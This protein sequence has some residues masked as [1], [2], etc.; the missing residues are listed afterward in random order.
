MY[1]PS[2]AVVVP[3][4]GNEGSITA[5]VVFVSAV[6]FCPLSP[7]LTLCIIIVHNTL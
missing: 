7:A 3:F 6:M 4:G 2:H 5:V 1:V